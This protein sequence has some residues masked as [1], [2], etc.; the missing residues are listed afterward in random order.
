MPVLLL[1]AGA[2]LGYGAVLTSI[3]INIQGAAGGTNDTDDPNARCLWSTEFKLPP[4]PAPSG[5][6]VQHSSSR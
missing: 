6:L 2:L 4:P 3:T 1:L 5:Y